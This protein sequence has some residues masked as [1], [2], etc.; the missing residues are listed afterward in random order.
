MALPTDI[1]PPEYRPQPPQ[2][3]PP[4]CF[5]AN[6]AICLSNGDQLAISECRPGMSIIGTRIDSLKLQSVVIGQCKKFKPS[7][8]IRITARN[9][10]IDTTPLHS[11][12]S[13]RG[14]RRANRLKI[15]DKLYVLNNNRL[16]LTEIDDIKIISYLEPVY[17]LYVPETGNFLANRFLVS[18]F[19]FF[20]AIR[21]RI[22]H[23]IARLRGK[24]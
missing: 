20:P 3:K 2:S 11:F 1:K 12:R 13:D 17:N 23:L 22:L 18:C 19:G 16:E 4:S 14:W 5:P 24:I 8:L 6:V 10:S 15:G 7:D 9:Y 21:I